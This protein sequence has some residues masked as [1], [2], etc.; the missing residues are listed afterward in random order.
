MLRWW[1]SSPMVIACAISAVRS[2]PPGMRASAAD[3]VGPS[4]SRIQARRV[5]TS[6]SYAPKRITLP[7]PSLRLQ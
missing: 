5:C 4:T 7:M 3:S 6:P 1:N 2:M